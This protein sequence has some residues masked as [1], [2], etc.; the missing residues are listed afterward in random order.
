MNRIVG[1][2]EQVDYECGHIRCFRSLQK[3]GF[4]NYGTQNN[5]WNRVQSQR[6]EGLPD[7]VGLE[8]EAETWMGSGDA[9]IS[10]KDSNYSYFEV[11]VCVGG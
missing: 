10:V 3:G 8:E 11:C 5:V 4:N 6:H 1:K 9:G 2:L 7:E